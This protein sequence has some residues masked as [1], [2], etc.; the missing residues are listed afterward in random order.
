MEYERQMKKY[1]SSNLERQRNR[2]EAYQTRMKYLHPG[3][4]LLQ[5]KQFVADIEE[6]LR[7]KMKERILE[8]RHGFSLRLEKMKGLSPLRK[9]NQGFSYVS[10]EQG[11]T[12]RTVEQICPGDALTIHVAD[13]RVR[14]RVE[15]VIQ[16]ER[17]GNTD[18]E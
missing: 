18:I 11:R 12:L 4:K 7:R 14:A 2:L 10:D 17:Y 8:A 9:L 1:L 16:E 13:G 3:M 6:E 15:E 5:Q